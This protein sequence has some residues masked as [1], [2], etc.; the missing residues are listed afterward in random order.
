MNNN[1]IDQYYTKPN[2]ALYVWTRFCDFIKNNN[3]NID[4]YVFIEPSAGSGNFL[5]L[6]PYQKRIGFDILPRSKEVFKFNY[7]DFKPLT[8]HIVIGNPPFG[9]RGE[10]ALKFINYSTF[11]DIICFILPQG[12]ESNGKSSLKNRVK[13]HKLVYSEKLPLDSF[14]Y[15]DGKNVSVSTVMQ[16][17]LKNIDKFKDIEEINKKINYQLNYIKIYSLSNGKNSSQKRNVNMINKCDLYI[18][19]TCFIKIRIYD[20]FNDLP[21]QRG[22]GIVINHKEKEIIINNIKK[23]DFERYSFKSTNSANNIRKELIEKSIYEKIKEL[24]YD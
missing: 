4:K 3:I 21:Y 9:T 15:P 19:S 20:N 23:I 10:M 5:K 12:F 13:N 7:F 8:K 14:I 16:I 6:L 17:W 22:Y 24:N 11:A 2:I 18:P 1:V